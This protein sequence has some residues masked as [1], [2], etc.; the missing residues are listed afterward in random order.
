VSRLDPDPAVA[1]RAYR[2]EKDPDQGGEVYDVRLTAA[3]W[4]ECDCPG[5]Q[6]HGH[7]K[8]GTG[9]AQFGVLATGEGV[10]HGA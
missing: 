3:G 8:H 7:C 4:V 1:L 6:R 5:N 2:L 10:G 9:L